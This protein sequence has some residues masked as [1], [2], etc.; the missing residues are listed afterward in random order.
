MI[1]K[2]SQFFQP[3]DRTFQLYRYNQDRH[4]E[5]CARVSREDASYLLSCGFAKRLSKYQLVLA[6]HEDVVKLR[7]ESC[8]IKESTILQ[9]LN[10]SEH[11]RAIIE[12]WRS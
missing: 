8:S 2:T 11:H 12:S 1:G 3:I 4:T 7:G 5:P 9:A 10:G 6:K